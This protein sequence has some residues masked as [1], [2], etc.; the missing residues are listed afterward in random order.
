[1]WIKYESG[2]N[3]EKCRVIMV[4]NEP[5]TLPDELLA[6]GEFLDGAMPEPDYLPKKTY[7]LYFN[8]TTKELWY[9]YKDAPPTPEELKDMRISQLEEQLRIT[10][11]AVDA[12]LLG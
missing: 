4:H 7:E 11:E 2:D 1:M 5:E 8:P 12:L 9:E 3:A 10:Q 6:Q